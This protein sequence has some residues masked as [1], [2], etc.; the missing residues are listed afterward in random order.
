MAASRQQRDDLAGAADQRRAWR[1]SPASSRSPGRFGQMNLGFPPSYGFTAII[2]AFLGRLHPLGVILAG[3]VLAVTYVGGEVAQTDGARAQ[4]Q[5]R[6]LPGDDAVLHSRQ[7]H[8]GPLPRA[9]RSRRRRA[10][11][12]RRQSREHR[13]SSSPPSSPSSALTT[14]ILLA[15]AGRTGGRKERRAQSRRRGH[16]ADRRHRRLCRRRCSPAT[17]GSA[18]W[19]RRLRGRW[20]RR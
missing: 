12:P 6:H 8:P 16:D 7:R 2:V 18:C 5:R 1:G 10:P 9:H 19:L 11:R 15:G 4:C 3:I 17:R 14:P 20:R 13:T